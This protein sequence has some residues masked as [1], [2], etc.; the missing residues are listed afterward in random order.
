MSKGKGAKRFHGT[1]VK[2]QPCQAKPQ[3]LGESLTL[4]EQDVGS[5]TS[6]TKHDRED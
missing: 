5:L 3:S 2:H 4:F 6:P 1:R